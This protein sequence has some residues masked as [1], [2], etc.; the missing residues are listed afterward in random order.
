MMTVCQNCGRAA[1]TKHVVYYQNI[2]VL[3][4]RF[5]RQAKGNFCR[6]CS[7]RFFWRYT[8]TTL[9]L[10]WWGIISFFVTLFVLGNNIVRWIGTWGMRGPD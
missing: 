2:G 8:L 7:S 1:E 6:D 3:V 10:G 5:F 4:M 9:V